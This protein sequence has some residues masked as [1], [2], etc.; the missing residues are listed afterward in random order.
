MIPREVREK[1]VD[2]AEQEIGGPKE[3][4]EAAVQAVITALEQG[5]DQDNT[6]AAA[7]QAADQWDLLHRRELT[8]RALG[9]KLILA[10]VVA[11]T[12][13]ILISELRYPAVILKREIRALGIIL[14]ADISALLI[15]VR[16]LKKR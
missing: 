11:V 7:R 6:V 5:E 2:W 8:P 12:T 9:R 10:L 16:L 15:L 14:L 1:W 4:I 13:M 3:R